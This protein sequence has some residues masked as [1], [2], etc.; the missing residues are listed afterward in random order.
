MFKVKLFEIEYKFSIK[1]NQN[2]FAIMKNGYDFL[3]HSIG[4]V[5]NKFEMQHSL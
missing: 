3:V 2:Y 1:V 4:W 5:D